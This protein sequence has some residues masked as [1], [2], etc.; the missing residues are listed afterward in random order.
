MCRSA[1]DAAIVLGAIAGADPRDPT[2]LHGCRC[3]TMLA[4]DRWQ[5]CSGMRIGFDR[6]MLDGLDADVTARARRCAR[7]CSARLGATILDVALPAG[8]DEAA[9]DWVPLL[10][11]RDAPSRTRRPIPR[12]PSEYGTGLAG[13]IDA[14]R[15][16]RGTDYQRISLRR[17]RLHRRAHRGCSA[18]VDLLLVP[19][20]PM[21]RRARGAWRRS[22]GSGRSWPR[23]AL[24]RAVRHV[25]ASDPDPAGRF[26]DGRLPV[27]VQ[28]VGRHLGEAAIL[29]VG[30]AFQRATDWHRRHPKV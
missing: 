5:A 28:F 10:R 7:A 25:R 1:A 9:L 29:R 15:R 12:A 21:P 8:F 26:D 4:A 23:A 19:A 27:G 17:A 20:M 18:P 30:R 11:G 3:P 6:A 24:H 22:A 13:L 2:A 16:C 14:G